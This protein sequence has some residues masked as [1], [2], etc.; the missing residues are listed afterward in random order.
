MDDNFYTTKRGDR[1]P[2]LSIT[3]RDELGPVD[4]TGYTAVLKVIN[5]LTGAT[6]INAA[7]QIAADPTF[8]ADAT[9][10]KLTLSGGS[11][12]PDQD[13]TLKSTGA[14]PGGLSASKQ[15]FAVN[16]VGSTCQLSETK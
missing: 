16:V 3:A 14:L 9:L 4:L 7:A 15:Y 11:V 13:V 12:V 2:V 8:T 6:K 10:D 1:L 5:V